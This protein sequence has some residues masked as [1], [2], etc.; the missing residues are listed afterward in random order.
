MARPETINDIEANDIDWATIN[1]DLIVASPSLLKA[2]ASFAEAVAKTTATVDTNYAH[3]VRM[4]RPPTIGELERQL[5]NE[6]SAWD[7]RQKCYDKL[8][9]FGQVEM[10][11]QRNYAQRHAEREGLPWPPP[12]KPIESIDVD[13]IKRIDEVLS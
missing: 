6:Q 5:N 1:V 13:V 3:S 11:Y 4:S 12:C 2:Y 9:D 7:E 8:K 10:D